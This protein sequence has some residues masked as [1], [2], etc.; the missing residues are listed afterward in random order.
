MDIVVKLSKSNY[1]QLRGHVLPGSAAYEPME[2]ATAFEH[3]V[4][5]VIFA[6]YSIA[7][8]DEQAR[9]LLDAARRHCPD[10][11]SEI[12]KSMTAAAP[13]R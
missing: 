3:S 9:A 11:V 1:R 12:E 7:C 2:K 4:E 5:G 8:D 6:G 13:A 10:A